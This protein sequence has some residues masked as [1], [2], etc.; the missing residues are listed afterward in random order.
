MTKQ[1]YLIT[2]IIMF[3]INTIVIST[4][5]ILQYILGFANEYI[6]YMYSGG[7]PYHLLNHNNIF[8]SYVSFVPITLATISLVTFYEYKNYDKNNPA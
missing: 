2:T 7:N 1:Y 8:L 4:M 5:V 3:I 6:D